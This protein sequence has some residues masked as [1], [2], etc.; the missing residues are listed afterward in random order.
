MRAKAPPR[1]QF[2]STVASC[3][4]EIKEITGVCM[5]MVW[6]ER[7]KSLHA[8][9]Y[10][11]KFGFAFC[12][13]NLICCSSNVTARNEKHLSIDDWHLQVVVFGLLYHCTVCMLASCLLTV[14][15]RFYLPGLQDA[16]HALLRT[17]PTKRLSCHVMIIFL[18]RRFVSTYG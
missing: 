13:F 18:G 10:Q 8:S 9:G 1:L 3:P 7:S 14:T 15:K 4:L 12:C 16:V 6:S 17:L 11:S 5:C 2:S